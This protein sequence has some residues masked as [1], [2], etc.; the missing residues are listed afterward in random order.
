M[1]ITKEKLFQ[2]GTEIFV[3][4]G[5]CQQEAEVVMDELVTANLYGVDSHGVIRIPQY[6]EEIKNGNII[7]NA[8]VEVV[9]ET[10]TTAV[11][12]GN[13]NFGQIVG[14]KM[15]AVLAEKAK[16]YALLRH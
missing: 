12:D 8:P 3:N 16:K 11:I 5:V 14:R 6:L 2:Y 9:K 4:A 15:V 1:I 7:P 10:A 13:H